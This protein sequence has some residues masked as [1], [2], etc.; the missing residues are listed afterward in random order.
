MNSRAGP[1]QPPAWQEWLGAPSETFVSVTQPGLGWVAQKSL[2]LRTPRG[3]VTP[4][5]S[6]NPEQPLCIRSPV[7][8]PRRQPMCRTAHGKR[9]PQLPTGRLW[10]QPRRWGQTTQRR[11]VGVRAS[12][13]FFYSRVTCLLG[14]VSPPHGVAPPRPRVPPKHPFLWWLLSAEAGGGG[15]V[16]WVKILPW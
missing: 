1:S 16:P 12:T 6:R 14:R 13:F 8:S 9:R 2:I 11:S 4:N 15:G 10:F 3:R 7:A 5:R